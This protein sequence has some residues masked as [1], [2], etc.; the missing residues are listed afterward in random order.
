MV[1]GLSHIPIAKLTAAVSRPTA[2][3]LQGIQRKLAHRLFW[4]Q[5]GPNSLSTLK[6]GPLSTLEEHLNRDLQR[7]EILVG[8]CLHRILAN[9][10]DVRTWDYSRCAA[11][12]ACVV[13]AELH[14]RACLSRARAR[15]WDEV[16][17]AERGHPVYLGYNPRKYRGGRWIL[18]SYAVE[19][20]AEWRGHANYRGRHTRQDENLNFHRDFPDQRDECGNTYWTRGG[21]QSRSGVL[22]KTWAGSKF[23]QLEDGA[24]RAKLELEIWAAGAVTNRGQERVIQ[25]PLIASVAVNAFELHNTQG[26]A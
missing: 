11:R 26:C 23:C 24:H 15:L 18:R 6:S 14:F 5:S 7:E 9:T 3:E 22:A 4:N 17:H 2:V 12:T 16:L 10:T 13:T 20:A 21:A 25:P 19:D 8:I 1:P